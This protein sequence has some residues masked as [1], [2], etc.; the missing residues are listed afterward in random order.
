MPNFFSSILT[1][2]KIITFIFLFLV[3][4]GLIIPQID[5]AQTG[6]E[7]YIGQSTESYRKQIDQAE[8]GTGRFK[9]SW[10]DLP[11]GIVKGLADTLLWICYMVAFVSQWLFGK[12]LDFTFKN[13][14]TRSAETGD[15][16]S[17]FINGWTSVRDFANMII[18]LGMVAIG[19]ATTI[20]FREY[21]AKRLLLPLI[22]IALLVNFSG[23]F[24]GLIIDGSNIT[25]SSL[26]GQ[27][28]DSS[29]NLAS[30]SQ[31]SNMLLTISKKESTDL[32]AA[33]NLW[34]YFEKLVWFCVIYIVMAIAFFMLAL[35]LLERYAML[36]MLFILS[37]AAFVFWVFPA[38]KKLWT[39]WW[40]HFLKWCFV[41]VMTLFFFNIATHMIGDVNTYNRWAWIVAL[42]FM[43][44]G[45][46]IASKSSGMASAAAIGLAGAAAATGL[47]AVGK[48]GLKGL[49]KASGTTELG[50]TIG[51]GA[52]RIAERMGLAKSG[53][54]AK[55]E[56]DRVAADKK[57]YDN[58]TSA[59]LAADVNR[60]AVTTS[61]RKANDIKAQILAERGD[62]GKV[63]ASS[64]DAVVK[65]AI[66]ND[67]TGGAL[68]SF[69]KADP[70]Y[71]KYDKEAVDKKIQETSGGIGAPPISEELAQ[72]MVVADQFQRA[73]VADIRGY[74]KN[75]L[76]SEEFTKNVSHKRKL[77]A[78]EQMST[79]GVNAMMEGIRT[80]MKKL[81]PD[82]APV[83]PRD[84]AK[85]D[86]LEKQLEDLNII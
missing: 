77:K 26:A 18:V 79:S 86:A 52:T 57:Q 72:R 15:N 5:F 28:K 56:K 16:A 36:A 22:L 6:D 47:G 74:D 10:Y 45:V 58:M 4:G 9:C 82:A 65:R 21:E 61:G 43:I 76:K 27:G 35:I 80:E 12:I 13:P 42:V 29:G 23:L 38:S 64:R 85:Y 31:G 19:I 41:G 11:C 59:Q 25:M 81:K 71:K 78:A 55:W 40:N 46:K 1:P 44:A 67:K 7:A 54:S 39:E 69:V 8:E 32:S 60:G 75:V 30:G 20:R 63:N 49:G 68:A 37:P 53:T 17:F 48:V 84:K 14:I 2:K 33:T 83:I 34:D 73:N 70:H 3:I 51:H 50:R 66:K 62:L 24:C